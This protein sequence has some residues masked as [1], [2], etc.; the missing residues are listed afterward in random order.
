[1]PNVR[2]AAVDAD[3][4][5]VVSQPPD[6]RRRRS[7]LPDDPIR[8]IDIE[9]AVTGDRPVSECD[10]RRV[11]PRERPTGAPQPTGHG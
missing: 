10:Q 9:A 11:R 3:P 4:E 1:M 8:G 5:T 6:R 2:A 7:R